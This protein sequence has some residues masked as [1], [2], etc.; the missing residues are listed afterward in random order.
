MT[1]SV[2]KLN[3]PS[4]SLLMVAVLGL[5]ST[6]T[7]VFWRWWQRPASM[8]MSEDWLSDQARTD[9]KQGSS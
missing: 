5:L 8:V 7:G 6:T 9:L 2:E 1:V 4:P 3:A